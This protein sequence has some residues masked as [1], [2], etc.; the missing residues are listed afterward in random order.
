MAKIKYGVK[1]FE[2]QIQILNELHHDNN[3]LASLK[4]GKMIRI[5]RAC[6]NEIFSLLKAEYQELLQA[7]RQLE[8]MSGTNELD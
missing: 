6:V 4:S 2:R 8:H 1:Y 7:A 5:P 3:H